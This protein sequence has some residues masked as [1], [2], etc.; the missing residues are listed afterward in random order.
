MIAGL[1]L[2]YPM[3]VFVLASHGCFKSEGESGYFEALFF[4][5]NVLFLPAIPIGLLAGRSLLERVAIMVIWVAASIIG[6]I[7][8]LGAG[9]IRQSFG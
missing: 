2:L 1:G 8:V 3:I 5:S 6:V 7:L 9:T 4:F